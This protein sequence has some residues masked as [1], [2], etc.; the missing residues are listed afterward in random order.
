ME[1]S[2]TFKHENCG[3]PHGTCNSEG[4]TKSSFGNL[5]PSQEKGC[6][7]NGMHF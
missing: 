3:Y 5:T 2:S 4:L 1:I 6:H 7:G